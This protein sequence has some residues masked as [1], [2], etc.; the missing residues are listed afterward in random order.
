[1]R[2]LIIA[3]FVVLASTTLAQADNQRPSVVNNVRADAIAPTTVRVSWNKPY[4]NVRVA[5][6]NIYR[7]GNYYKT[8][9]NTTNYLDNGVGANSS[10]NYSISAFD[11][12]RNYSPISSSTSVSTG[13]DN[14]PRAVAAA[15]QNNNG[16]PNA[17]SGLRAEAQSSSEIK[18]TWNS[19][20]NIDGYN[21]YR[22][23]NYFTTVKGRTHY[24]ARS[25]S[26]GKEYRFQVVAFNN[27]RYSTKSGEVRARTQGGNQNSNSGNPS[28]GTSNSG[29]GAV[30]NGYTLVFSDEFRGRDIDSSKWN[31]RYR[32]GPWQTINNEQ[33]FYVDRLNDRNFGY[34]PF[35]FDGEHLSIVAKPTP[36]NLR[37]KANN[38][39]YLSGAMT[40]YQKFKMRYGYVEMRAKLPKGKGLWP[41]FWLLHN[42]ENGKRPEIDVVELLGDRPNIAY[43][44]YHYYDNWNL[45]STPSYE[46]RGS[47]YTQNFHTYGMK[48][49][50]GRI[51]WYV[52]GKA[53]NSF[54]N[55]NVSSEDM[56]LL[57][58]LAIGGAWAGSPNGST[59]FPAK[60]TI[61][62]IRAYRRP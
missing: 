1:M 33:Q 5:G 38:K 56:Y 27:S 61:D 12:A 28:S 2:T 57:V 16:T 46:A 54:S 11:D 62:Y 39:G 24:T 29:S 40:T 4:D 7:N 53:T 15:P 50:P 48:W 36:G 8:V 6:Y 52:D 14:S 19:S 32:W 21:L 41:A 13:G 45:R 49:E 9:F 20:G 31:T 37:G 22:D 25:L 43:Q 55:G 18:L 34:S 60:Y 26:S 58:N 47:D 35:E 42:Q 59:R 23:G 51:T 44:T 10:Y 17:P 3:F 30:P